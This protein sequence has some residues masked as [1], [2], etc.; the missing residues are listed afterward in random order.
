M[1]P[2]PR[3]EDER[4]G[5]SDPCFAWVPV[6][7]ILPKPVTASQITLRNLVRSFSAIVLEFGAVPLPVTVRPTLRWTLV[8]RA[9]ASRLATTAVLEPAVPD[10]C[11]VGPLVEFLEILGVGLSAHWC[12]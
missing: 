4:T 10:L 7:D 8:A 9:F 5:A 11:C 2:L 6:V 3:L 1:R 12:N